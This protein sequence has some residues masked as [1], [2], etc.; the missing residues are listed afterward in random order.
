MSCRWSSN[1]LQMEP[2]VEQQWSNIELQVEQRWSSSEL[3]VELRVKQRWSSGGATVEQ[4]WCSMK[5]RQLHLRRKLHGLAVEA[6][7]V[8]AVSSRWS[9]GELQMELLVEQQWSSVEVQVEQRCGSSELQVEQ[10]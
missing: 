8:E 7:R 2:L 10:Q 1:E 3:Q 4:R 9:S 5:E 6:L